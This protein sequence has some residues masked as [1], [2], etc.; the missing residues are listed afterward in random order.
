MKGTNNILCHWWVSTVLG[1]SLTPQ[2]P[3][4][5]GRPTFDF[6]CVCETYPDIS[7]PT[8]TD[9]FLRRKCQSQALA[10]GFSDKMVI[11]CNPQDIHCQLTVQF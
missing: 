5:A 11:A 3:N 10:S 6:V 7:M 4:F 2:H 1:A 9:A 8:E